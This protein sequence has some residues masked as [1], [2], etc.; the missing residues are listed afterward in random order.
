MDSTSSIHSAS[1]AS[2]S[3]GSVARPESA[4]KQPSKLFCNLALEQASTTPH[5]ANKPSEAAPENLLG[6]S[7]EE[8]DEIRTA[9]GRL[10]PGTEGLRPLRL[11]SRGRRVELRK[12]IQYYPPDPI[13]KGRSTDDP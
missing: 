7:A 5:D 13:A 8:V 6:L 12:R 2:I 4:L 1:D 3:T 10:R 11:H 9:A